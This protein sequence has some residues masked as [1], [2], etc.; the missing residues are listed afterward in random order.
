MIVQEIFNQPH[1]YK[2][3]KFD[4]GQ[5]A[6]FKNANGEKVTVSFIAY[7]IPEVGWSYE[8]S[9]SV[10]DSTELTGRGDEI[11]TFSTITAI[12]D[13]FMTK[14]THWKAQGKPILVFV[15]AG[16]TKRTSLYQ[17]L[18]DKIAPKYNFKIVGANALPAKIQSWWKHLD[19]S[20]GEAII[21][22][23]DYMMESKQSIMNEYIRANRKKFT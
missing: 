10:K 18:M 6:T 20:D 8:I 11:R 7:H 3:K 15:S 5:A 9:F 17:K 21:G 19:F 4:D 2:L 14:M 1:A 13:E 16:S 22:I 12:V 23:R